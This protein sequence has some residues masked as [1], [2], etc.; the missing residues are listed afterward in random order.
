MAQDCDALKS[1]GFGEKMGPLHEDRIGPIVI[2]RSRQLDWTPV[3][4]ALLDYA[5]E[6]D[7]ADKRLRARISRGD[8]LH[9]ELSLVTPG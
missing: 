9:G 8:A 3:G 5:Q 1:V 7:A 6:T 4:L 2:R